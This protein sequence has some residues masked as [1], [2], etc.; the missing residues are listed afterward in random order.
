VGRRLHPEDLARLRHRLHLEVRNP[1]KFNF[2][3]VSN[4]PQKKSK[5]K[6]ALKMKPLYWNKLQQNA[7]KDTIWGKMTDELKVGA[8]KKK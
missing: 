7:I 3:V 5:Y 4:Q 6:P 1:S 8:G 2:F